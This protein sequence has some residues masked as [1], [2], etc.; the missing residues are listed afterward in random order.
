MSDTDEYYDYDEV[1]EI[2]P[3]E[4]VRDIYE[5]IKLECDELFNTLTEEELLTFLY[6]EYDI[7]NP[8]PKEEK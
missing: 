4:H 2:L 1:I 7:Y 6:P 3:Q 8:Y 5:C